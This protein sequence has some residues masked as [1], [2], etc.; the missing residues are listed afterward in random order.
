MCQMVGFVVRSVASD[1]H[2]ELLLQQVG[3]M[4]RLQQARF[5]KAVFCHAVEPDAFHELRKESYA[6]VGC[7]VAA[8]EIDREI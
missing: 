8:G 3:V 4:V 7:H 6:A 2:E 1:L 5:S